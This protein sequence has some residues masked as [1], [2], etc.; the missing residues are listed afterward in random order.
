MSA[1][2]AKEVTG[3]PE[4]VTSSETS[5]EWPHLIENDWVLNRHS[6]DDLAARFT[7]A[8]LPLPEQN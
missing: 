2:K 4:E 7:N 3:E 5:P 8:S 1:T 6:S